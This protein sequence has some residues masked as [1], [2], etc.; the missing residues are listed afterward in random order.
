MKAN[1]TCSALLSLACLLVLALPAWAGSDDPPAR[2]RDRERRSGFP[3]KVYS[4]EAVVRVDDDHYVTI[5]LDEPNAEGIMDGFADHVFTLALA[6]PILELPPLRDVAAEV[7]VRPES[8]RALLHTEEKELQFVLDDAQPSPQPQRSIYRIQS[9]QG[10]LAF[11]EYS[12][13]VAGRYSL[14]EI[15]RKGIRAVQELHSSSKIDPFVQ[16]PDPSTDGSSCLPSC[17][18]T[19]LKGSCT[20]SCNSGYC[21]KCNCI[22]NNTTPSCYCV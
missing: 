18:K 16:P 19:C 4:G 3:V 22:V 21:A 11:Y 13:A 6:Q 10:G 17:S 2:E 8:V 9:F 5:A 15:E 1:R 7:E 20:A 12:G 14:D